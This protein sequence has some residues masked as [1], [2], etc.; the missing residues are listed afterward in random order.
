[1]P[2]LSERER[3]EKLLRRGVLPLGIARRNATSACS[4]ML[5]PPNGQCARASPSSYQTSGSSGYNRAAP[6]SVVKRRLRRS[7]QTGSGGSWYRASNSDSDAT[8]RLSRGGNPWFNLPARS[9]YTRASESPDKVLHS[10]TCPSRLQPRQ[11]EL[12][13]STD[14]W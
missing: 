2:T 6:S 11:K 1:M 14:R 13:S 5:R 3:Q 10:V 8:S 9:R 7:H 12:S 4:V